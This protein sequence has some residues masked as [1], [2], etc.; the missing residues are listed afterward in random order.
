MS[1]DDGSNSDVVG[2][3]GWGFNTGMELG[4]MCQSTNCFDEPMPM[5]I[6]SCHM[7]TIDSNKWHSANSG[8][9]GE[10]P[11]LSV[12]LH[13]FGS[14]QTGFDVNPTNVRAISTGRSTELHN[15]L[16]DHPILLSFLEA[17]DES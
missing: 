15:V 6:L 11:C 17:Q 4:L 1:N 10:Q 8:C 12:Q 2:I 14:L 13:S 7:L 5:N 9:F 3:V 16:L